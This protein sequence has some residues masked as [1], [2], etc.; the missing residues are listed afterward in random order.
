M[1]RANS[2]RS[3][4]VGMV[5]I[6][7][8]IPVPLAYHTFGGWKRSAFGDINQ[9]GPEGVRFYTR[10]K[11]VTAAL[12]QRRRARESELRHPDDE[13]KRRAG[14]MA[15]LFEPIIG[16]AFSRDW[17]GERAAISA[18]SFGR[19]NAPWSTRPH[20]E[21]GRALGSAGYRAPISD[22]AEL[23][24]EAISQSARLTGLRGGR[25]YIALSEFPLPPSIWG[26]REWSPPGLNVRESFPSGEVL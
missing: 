15:L 4:K 7:I 2:P 1:P 14:Q 6:N 24:H 13:I 11:T 19:N 22:R 16:V 21:I 26:L 3:V 17:P 9:H 23:E 18:L 8:P 12:A 20:P 25:F 5:G 10:I